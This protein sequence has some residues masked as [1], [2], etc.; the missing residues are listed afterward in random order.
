MVI[1]NLL[2]KDAQ[3]SFSFQWLISAHPAACFAG[4]CGA[5][6]C[7]TLICTRHTTPGV[8]FTGLS[9]RASALPP[10]AADYVLDN[11]QQWRN[12]LQTALKAALILYLFDRL[13]LIS[14]MSWLESHIDCLSIMVRCLCTPARS[15]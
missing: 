3:N 6:N 13:R 5:P 12:I 9:T 8:P 2:G 1:Y 4:V 14:D 7:V 10:P 15:H 11:A